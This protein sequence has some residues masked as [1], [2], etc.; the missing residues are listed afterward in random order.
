MKFSIVTISFNQAEYLE[1]TILSVINQNYP[2]I[3]YIIVDPGS[4]DNSQEIILKY[5]HVFSHIIFEPDQGPADGLNKGFKRATGDIF[6]FLNSDDILL[7]NTLSKV[8]RFFN[9]HPEI[10]VVSGHSTIINEY[11]RKIRN[12]YSDPFYLLGY[13]YGS[14]VQMQPSTFFRAE[15]FRRTSGF[16]VENKIG[17][18]AELFIEM[19][20]RGAK[21]AL[22]DE[23]FSG[24][25]LHPQSIT[26][27][28]S[29][30]RDEEFRQHYKKMFRKIMGRDIQPFDLILKGFLLALKY[31][32]DPRHLYERL[33][34][35]PIYG[36]R[37]KVRSLKGS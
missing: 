37:N 9:T 11:E 2:E 34:K 33:L 21:F 6:Y 16:N 32:R 28:K 27:S 17:W 8:A 22:K 26:S 13:A 31:A 7:D 14:I 29:K 20:M 23:F 36:R 5:S 4:T 3:E 15:S 25:R 30:K 35:G 18:D 10:D 12:G 19:H 24:Y 1:R